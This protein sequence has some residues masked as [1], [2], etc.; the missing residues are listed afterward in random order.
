MGNFIVKYGYIYPLQDPKNLTL[1]PDSSLYRFQVSLG[2]DTGVLVGQDV[3]WSCNWLASHPPRALET[4]AEVQACF[5]LRGGGPGA[6]SLCQLS[7][8]VSLVD[9]VLLA[10]PAVAG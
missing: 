5:R 7:P 6:H 10:H 4:V 3:I 9:A 1:K 8:L 2:L